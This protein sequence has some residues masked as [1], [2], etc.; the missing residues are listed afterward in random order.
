MLFFPPTS[1]FC[2]WGQISLRV[3]TKGYSP[4]L[5][6]GIAQGFHFLFLQCCHS[7]LENSEYVFCL[8]LEARVITES[9]S[10]VRK[11]V[12]LKVV[13]QASLVYK[14]RKRC[15]KETKSK[16]LIQGGPC[17]SQ[18]LEMKGCG[19]KCCSEGKKE[20][21]AENSSFGG[22]ESTRNCPQMSAENMG[23]G[24]SED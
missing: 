22:W 21:E 15:K 3:E 11:Q 5:K 1:V 9:S 2:L 12:E 7:S 4:P 19:N 14:L 24:L 13:F 8:G 23:H 18:G 10:Q 16:T 6:E 20:R 17:L